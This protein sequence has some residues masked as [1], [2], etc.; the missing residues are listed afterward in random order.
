M[1]TF[2]M[3]IKNKGLLPRAVSLQ[4][5]CFTEITTEQCVC[6]SPPGLSEIGMVAVGSPCLPQSIKALR[7]CQVMLRG[8][9]NSSVQ[10]D[11]AVEHHEPP[12]ATNRCLSAPQHHIHCVNPW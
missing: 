3:C 6:Q 1:L 5:F 8:L 7:G 9:W 4:I 2:L 11:R 12:G 10:K